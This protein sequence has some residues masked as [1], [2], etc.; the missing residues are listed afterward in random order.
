VKNNLKMVSSLVE[1]KD[2][3]L[4]DAVDLSDVSHQINA[5]QIVHQKLHQANDVR[6]VDLH[7]YL[8]DLLKTVFSSFTSKQVL[9]HNTVPHL[10]V[11]T[12]TAVALGLIVNEIATNAIKY[13]FSSNEQARF[14]ISLDEDVDE[15]RYVL[16]IGNTGHPL[17][18]HQS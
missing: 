5:I 7:G 8:D 16:T 2:A 3:A 11:R 9:V 1:L 12:K 4:G 17:P 13:G 14:H 18:R 6:Y 10:S 15:D